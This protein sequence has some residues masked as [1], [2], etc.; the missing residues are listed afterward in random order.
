V[1]CYAVLSREFQQD[2]GVLH[3]AAGVVDQ[4]AQG[5]LDPP[6]AEPNPGPTG[7]RS[8]GAAVAAAVAYVV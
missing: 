5:L 7:G 2:P 6:A 1:A 3:S 8:A 4:A